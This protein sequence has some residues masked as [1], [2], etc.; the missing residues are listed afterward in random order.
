LSNRVNETA[1]QG[2][3]KPYPRWKQ[4]PPVEIEPHGEAKRLSP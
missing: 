2:C 4:T 1:T 3:S